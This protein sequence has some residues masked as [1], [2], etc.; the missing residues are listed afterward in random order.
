MTSL[1]LC[2]LLSLNLRLSSCFRFYLWRPCLRFCSFHETCLLL[3]IVTW[4]LWALAC[5]TSVLFAVTPPQSSSSRNSCRCRRRSYENEACVVVFCYSGQRL[6]SHEELSP[7]SWSFRASIVGDGTRTYCPVFFVRDSLVGRHFFPVPDIWPC[8]WCET[9]DKHLNVVP[10]AVIRRATTSPWSSSE[11]WVVVNIFHL[12]W[13][14]PASRLCPTRLFQH[15]KRSKVC[16]VASD[17][18][19]DKDIELDCF[20][21]D[22]TKTVRAIIVFHH[23]DMRFWGQSVTIQTFRLWSRMIVHLLSYRCRISGR[24][25]SD[26]TS[27]SYDTILDHFSLDILCSLTRREDKDHD[28]FDDIAEPLVLERRKAQPSRRRKTETKWRNTAHNSRKRLT[29]V[30]NQIIR[31][32]RTDLTLSKSLRQK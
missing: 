30:D 7:H 1:R 11:E 6:E 2:S 23:V 5:S 16:C 13:V 12:P 14:V 28:G 3:A 27:C 25:Y 15:P 4:L 29:L 22:L 9:V 10:G 20:I 8:I 32:D 19:C 21:L 17:T 18:T 24:R 26:E 31:V